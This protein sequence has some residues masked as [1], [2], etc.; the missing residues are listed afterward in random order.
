MAF[1]FIDLFAGIGGMRLGFE[2]AAQ[3]LA[4]EVECVFTS[5]IKP[6]ALEILKQNN[7]SEK[8]HGDIRQV[9]T[10]EI[11]D[12]D[13][14]LAGFPCQAFSTAG[15]RDGFL[16]TRGTLFFEVERILHSKRPKAFLLENVE[17]LITH[18]RIDR[19]QTIGRTLS[20]I[21]T[22][23][24]AL[25]Y[26]TDWVCLNAR[27][28]GV[29]QER[30]R[31]YIVGSRSEIPLLSNFETKTQLLKNVLEN[32]LPTTHSPFIEA[33]MR[34]Y[35][36][37]ELYGKSVKDKRGGENNVHSWD[38]ALKGA[39]SKKQ[40]ELLNC[41]FKERRKKKWAAEYGIKWMD[42]MP[43]TYEQIATFFTAPNLLDLLED[44]VEKG[45]LKKEHPKKEVV[46]TSNGLLRR[47]RVGDETLPLGYNIVSGKLSFEVNKI[48]APYDV[49]PTLVA[50]DMQKLFVVDGDGLRPLS[51]REGLRLF[52]YPET[53]RFDIDP[54][55]GYDLLGNTVAVPVIRAIAERLLEILRREES[56]VKNEVH[57]TRDLPTFG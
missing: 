44:L 38:L 42:G 8:I 52:G 9:A 22:H 28:F 33:L 21:L 47:Y 49:A 1:R 32:G 56:L 5:E 30:K 27:D 19:T 12:F 18:D 31:V 7:P 16:D 24:R 53:F 15:K 14:L 10:N 34:T 41:L 3:A 6:A 46:I 13:V 40:K 36:L 29:P 20:T 26:Q 39:V 55:Q 43:L 50:T 11:P 54:K 2:M 48:L 57:C 45:Y 51:L 37:D 4:M 23:L 25:G 17:G 35:A